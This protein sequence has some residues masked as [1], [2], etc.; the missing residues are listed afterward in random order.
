[1]ATIEKIQRREGFVYKAKVRK[2]GHPTTTRS[3]KT[4]TAAERWARK[5]EAAIDDGNAGLTNEAQKHTLKQ[6]IKRYREEVLPS[7]RP[8]TARKYKQHLDHWQE[9]LGHL[10]LS[11]CRPDKIAA[12]RDKLIQQG[13]SPATCNR[14]LSSLGSVMSTCVKRWHWLPVSPMQQVQKAAGENKSTRYLSDNELTRLL[15]ACRESES[16]DLLLAV[17]LSITTGA[18]QGEILGLRWKDV[19]LAAGIIR[20]R[21]DVETKTKGGIRSLPIAAQVLPLL[22]ARFDDWQTRQKGKVVPL[23]D[24]QLLFPSKTSRNQPIRLRRSW[25]TALGRAGISNFRWHDLR[26]SCASF[27]AKGGASLIEIGAVLG[28]KSANTTKRYAHLTEKHGHDL[29]R[30]MADELLGVGE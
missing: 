1:M 23:N 9:E 21:A 26:H 22:K 8:E 29:L 14:Y 3:F 7:L 30:G 19:D 17:L 11:D 28:H 27:L 20:V 15:K 25:V 10:R 6:A 12:V 18:R 5:L 24:P 4:R 13:K 16:S 2:Q